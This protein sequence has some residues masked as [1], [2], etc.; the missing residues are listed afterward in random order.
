MRLAGV[1]FQGK[2]WTVHGRRMYAYDPVSHK[3]IMTRPIRL[4]T[5][6][7]PEGLRIFPTRLVAEYQGSRDALVSPP[8]STVKDAT[9]TYDP[10]TGQWELL[11]EAPIG[12][13]TLVSTREGV[14]GV[15][16]NWPTRLNDAGYLLP[17][18]PSQPP[19]DKAIFLLDVAHKRWQK[20][21]EGQPSPQNLYEMSSLAY[22]SKRD[23]VILHGAGQRRD[24]LW[25]FDIHSH[26]WKNMQPAVLNPQGAM[27][28]VCAREAV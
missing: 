28:P 26:R 14:M 27:P 10:T 4:T 20:L 8:S 18:S 13:D 23:Q 5:G 2:P 25:T 15:N 1:T 6:Y 24:E 21:S 9:W 22:D 3:M 17:W 12:V 19:E 11:G 7:D 16:I